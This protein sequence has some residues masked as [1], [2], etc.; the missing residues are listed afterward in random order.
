V[1]EL[2]EVDRVRQL[3]SPAMANAR[4]ERVVLNRADLRQP[5]PRDF[6]RRLRGQTVSQLLRRGKYLLATLSS[7]DVLLMHLGM[8]GSFRV[9]SRPAKRPRPDEALEHRHDHV[10]FTMSS[11]MTVTFNDPRRF[12]VMD[13]LPANGGSHTAI[14]RMGPE[15][16]SRAF[17]ATALAARCAGRKTSLKAALLDQRVVAGLG[18]IYASEA[19]HVA[20][21]S[22]LRLANTVA[23][24]SG[25]PRPSAVRLVA[26]IKSVLRR[27]IALKESAAYRGIRFKVYER[28]GERCPTNGCRG[29]ILRIWQAGRSTF[30]CPVCQR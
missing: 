21:L 7:G 8:S 24:A 25:R 29:T 3:L 5:F 20:R 19:L 9:E 13:L 2:P 17:D 14:E 28:E 18:N 27:A 6:A 23:T 1:P 10:V 22:P 15:P 26:A 11:G 30:Y 16:L 12:G 4:F